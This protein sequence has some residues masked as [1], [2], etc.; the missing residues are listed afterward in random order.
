MRNL[1]EKEA[2]AAMRLFLE[3]N[4]QRC[5]DIEVAQVLSDTDP[6]IWTDGETGDP[7][8]FSEWRECVAEI[9]NRRLE[10]AE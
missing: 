6:D 9:V 4:W 10:A 7:G 8:A 3:R 5:G 2:F 1:S